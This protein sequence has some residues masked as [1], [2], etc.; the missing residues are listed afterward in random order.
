MGNVWQLALFSIKITKFRAT[1]CFQYWYTNVSNATVS[2]CKWK[3]E[4]KI[5]FSIFTYINIRF[6]F[7]F[8]W[9][10]CRMVVELKDDEK[11]PGWVKVSYQ[12][13]LSLSTQTHC[14]SRSSVTKENF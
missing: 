13:S 4:S 11:R 12:E 10:L 2:Y 1:F 8:R 9:I 5:L 3:H 7:D 6:L 14:K